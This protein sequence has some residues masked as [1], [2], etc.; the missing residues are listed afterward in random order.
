[1][2]YEYK[3]APLPWLSQIPQHWGLARNKTVLSETKE[4]VG[5]NHISY[6]LL[7]LTKGGVIIRDLLTGKG[8]FPSDFG[9]YKIVNDGQIIFCLFDIDETP[10]TVGL[11][12]YNGMIT[13]AYDVFSISGANPRYIEYYYLSLDDV[14]AMRPL[15]T[16]LRKVIGINTFMQ[17]HI[18]LPPR[19]EQDQI[20]RYLDWKVSQINKLINAK[21]RQIGL[22]QEKRQLLISE[23]LEGNHVWLKRV[24][25][26][27]FQYGA[28]ESGVDYSP[29]LPRYIRI[30]DISSDGKLKEDGAKS[31]NDDV[32]I[33]Y[34]LDDGDIL[35][36]RSGATAGKAF[37]YKAEHGS[38]AYAGYLIR[39]KIDKNVLLPEYFMYVVSGHDYDQW[40]NSIFIQATIQ[41]ISAERYGQLPIPIP[42]MTRQQ[43]IVKYLDEN[44]KRIDEIV[45]KLN[46]E[47]R[48]FAEY[49]TRLVSDVVTGKKDVRSVAVPQYETIKDSIVAETD[50]NIEEDLHE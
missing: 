1:M 23:N 11:S 25:V 39:A 15:Y 47:I 10:R 8:K 13:G 24:L 19:E 30:T 31:L 2:S 45:S 49:R 40:K 28:N 32:S 22:L 9:T 41:N 14:K 17:T 5:A 38:C 12:K 46:E 34:I 37:L 3:T 29:S 27:P 50:C 21:R 35:L 7:S 33:L 6:Q 43:V 42:T 36:A 44:C 4:T 18:P 48:L 26:A 20:V 16:G